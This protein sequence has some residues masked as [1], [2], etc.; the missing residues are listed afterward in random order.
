MLA[1]QRDSVHWGSEDSLKT[2]HTTLDFINFKMHSSKLLL[3]LLFDKSSKLLQLIAACQRLVKGH[4][5]ARP[6]GKLSNSFARIWY[7]A[8]CIS[9]QAHYERALKSLL[10]ESI[11]LVTLIT[12]FD[13]FALQN[14]KKDST[15]QHPFKNTRLK[16]KPASA[17]PVE[18]SLVAT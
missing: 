12:G 14:S 7:E 6:P 10:E 3:K 16:L 8:A 5:S 11:T 4:S 1:S 15:I 17:R 13:K 18:D 2:M 9:G